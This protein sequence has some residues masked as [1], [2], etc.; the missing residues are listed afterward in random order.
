MDLPQYD[1]PCELQSG[2]TALYYT[3]SR[4]HL[5]ALQLLLA[6]GANPVAA[7]QVRWDRGF[8]AIRPDSPAA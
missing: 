5:K 3:A 4:G 8:L 7:T 6:V 2:C 1:A